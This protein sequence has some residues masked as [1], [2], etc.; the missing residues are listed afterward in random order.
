[1]VGT[2]IVADDKDGILSMFIV[3]GST[4]TMYAGFWMIEKGIYVGMFTVSKL[5]SDVTGVS[6]IVEGWLYYTGIA[7]I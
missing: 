4:M 1:M 5:G 6:S 7:T 2:E 3:S